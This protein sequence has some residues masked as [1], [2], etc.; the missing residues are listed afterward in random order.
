MSAAGSWAIIPNHNPANENGEDMK[1]EGKV[2]II[3]GGGHGIGRTI[4]LRFGDEGA[5]LVIAGPN[6]ETV[7]KTVADIRARGRQAIATLTDVSDEASV[8]GMV[9]D[10]LREFGRVDVLVNNAGIIGPTAPVT[11]VERDQWDQALAVNLTG[12]ML[13]AKHALPS[14]IERCEGRIINITS[15]A[16][17]HAYAFRSPYSVSKWGMIGL[18]R[19]LAEE[20]GSYNIT[21]NAI[22]PGPVRGPR[23]EEVIRRRAVELGRPFDEVEREYVQPTALKRMVEEEDIAAMALFLASDEGRNITGETI[24][25]SSGYRL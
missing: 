24:T 6:L 19:T 18:T 8:E 15:V 20:A 17:Q 23:I 16:G 12:A 25:I 22:A 4:A 21:V 1:L 11:R 7:E 9:A 5:A 3:T 2:S 10:C 14:M 13:C